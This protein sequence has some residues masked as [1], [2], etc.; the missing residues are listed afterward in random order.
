MSY[1]NHCNNTTNQKAGEDFRDS[2]IQFLSI[3]RNKN[4][5]IVYSTNQ[6][7][8]KNRFVNYMKNYF[9]FADFVFLIN[10]NTDK[11]NMKKI[12]PLNILRFL[13]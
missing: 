4:Q 3:R 6:F 13:F 1:W 11:S 2:L 9:C 12:L 10:Y 7:I 8:S 5:N